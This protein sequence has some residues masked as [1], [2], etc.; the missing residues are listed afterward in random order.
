MFLIRY[1]SVH[2]KDEE[3]LDYLESKSMRSKLVHDNFTLLDHLQPL[4]NY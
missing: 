1:I 2:P 3:I 4:L